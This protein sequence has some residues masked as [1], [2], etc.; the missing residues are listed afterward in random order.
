MIELNKKEIF[1]NHV[2]SGYFLFFFFNTNP[3]IPDTHEETTDFYGD[4]RFLY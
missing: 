4:C 3:Y 2:V 1:R